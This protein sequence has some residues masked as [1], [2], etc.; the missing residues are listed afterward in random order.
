MIRDA[1]MCRREVLKALGCS[2]GL[3]ATIDS[4][5]GAPRMN[6]HTFVLVHPAWHGGWFW[7]K[8]AP[9]LRRRG[10]RVITPTL[11]GVGERSHLARPEIGLD[12]HITDV[13]NVLV[14]ENLRDVVLVGHSSSGVVITGVADRAPDRIARLVYLD[15]FVPDTDQGVFDLVAPDRRHVLEELVRTEGDGWLLPRFAPPPWETIVRDLWGVTDDED[16][17]WMLERLGPTPV[18][19]FRD[20]VRRT[21]P[22]A[23]RLRRV[24]IRCRQFPSPRF[25]RH[26]EMAQRGGLWRYHELDASH[27]AAVTIPDKVA[28][29]LLEIAS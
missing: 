7:K 27:H 2:A 28:A 20:R 3:L 16:V 5:A 22:A 19:H 13:V 6:T 24:Y 11:T 10:H 12:V 14:Y 8:V 29:V 21:N 9:L 18:G 23:E 1:R 26:A 17:G 15:A 4:A 25:D